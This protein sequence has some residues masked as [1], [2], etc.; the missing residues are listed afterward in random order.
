M[1]KIGVIIT[2]SNSHGGVYQYAQS[3]LSA[4]INDTTNTYVIFTNDKNLPN[5]YNVECRIIQLNKQSLVKRIIRYFALICGVRNLVFLSKDDWHKYH[6]IDL[7]ISPQNSPDPIC[8]LNKPYIF[9]MHDFQDR[10]YPEFF[11]LAERIIRRINSYA[12]CKGAA[13]IIVESQHVMNDVIKF[14]DADQV[15]VSVVIAPP[16]RAITDLNRADIDCRSVKKKYNLPDK[17]LFYP[18]QTWP[19]KNHLSLLSAVQPLIERDDSL[20]VVF[21][22]SKNKHYEKIRSEIHRLGLSKNFHFLGYI[23]YQD[24]PAL[25]VLSKILVLPTLFESI[26]IPIYEAFKLGVPVCCSNAVALP[27]QVGNAAVLF[28]PCDIEQIRDSILLL[29]NDSGLRS[30]CVNNGYKRIE[31]L[32]SAD[33]TKKLVSI[34]DSCF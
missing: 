13:R 20:Y 24:L 4:L 9:T 3:M 11:T 28:D 17:Y 23:D 30:N 29:L 16:P 10:Y 32:L 26:S 25:Y 21:T 19:H 22:G 12:L 15:K 6:D 33:Y 7:F 5:I 2:A 8:F 27:D 18:A 1:K 31:E 14:T 34:I